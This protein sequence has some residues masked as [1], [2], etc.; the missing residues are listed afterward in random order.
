MRLD[1]DFPLISRITSLALNPALAAGELG[2]TSLTSR[3]VPLEIQLIGEFL[4][5]RL[6]AVPSRIA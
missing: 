6:Y 4:R 5:G 3:P 2:V 1:T